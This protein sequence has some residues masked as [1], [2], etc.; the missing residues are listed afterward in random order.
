MKLSR[1]RRFS[2]HIATLVVALIVFA[3]GSLCPVRSQS[4]SLD[5]D[6]GRNML[7]MVKRDIR[8]N[9][10]DPAFHGIDLDA[11]F[12][13][14]DEKIK[15]ATGLGQIFGIIAQVLV[16]F[17]DSHTRFYPPSWSARTEYGWQMQ[18]IGDNCYV[19]AVKPGSDAEAKGLKPGD[20]IYSINSYTPTRQTLPTLRYIYYTLSPQKSL[21]V[22]AQSPG[23]QPRQLE[24]M[25][26]VQ[27]GKQ[28]INLTAIGDSDINDFIREIEK[29]ALSNPHRYHDDIGDVFIWKMPE[30]NL[31]QAKVDEAMDKARKHKALILDLRGNPGGYEETLL[32]LLSNLFEREVKVGD[33]TRRKEQKPLIAK[34]RGKD[35]FK[36]QLVVLIDS[37]SGSAAELLARTVQMEKRGTIVGDRTAGAVMRAKFF[38]HALGTDTVIPYGVSV[39][40]ADVIM[41]D[42]K[43]LEHLGVTPDTLILPTA[44]DMAAKRDPVLAYAAQL[45]GVKITPEKAGSLFPIEWR[46]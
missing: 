3:S 7:E 21:Q 6:R 34:P 24:I 31:V 32:R 25:A 41:T 8:K 26:K 28:V 23:G 43:S 42:G 36:G 37:E 12:K 33:L 20:M 1:L 14:A 46:K 15:Q 29:E 5:R 9:Y 27:Q 30:F 18:M 40:D 2:V 10:Y 19:V 44:E 4:L 35:I 22:L 11:R 39:T 17:N 38:D 13:A 16:E 45:V